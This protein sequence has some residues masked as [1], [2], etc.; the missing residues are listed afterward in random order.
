MNRFLNCLSLGLVTLCFL[1]LYT[2]CDDE[3]PTGGTDGGLAEGVTF[4]NNDNTIRIRLVAEPDRLSPF[5]TTSGYARP[6]YEQIFL[7]LLEHN[8]GTLNFEPALATARP[9]IEE[10]TEGPNA[11]GVKYTYEL[12]EGATFHDG[13]PVTVEDVIFSFKIPFNLNIT[14]AAP[15]RPSYGAVTDIV[16]DPDN[17]RRF[18]VITNQKYILAEDTYN[19]TGV[20]PK[21]VF[22]PDGL[23]DAYSYAQLKNNGEALASEAALQQFA[24]QFRSAEFSRSPDKL[25]GSGPYRLTGWEEGRH[26]TMSRVA[27]W[28]ADEIDHPVLEAHPDSLVFKIIT[29]QATA[30]T[31]VKSEEVDLARTLD[32]LALVDLRANE[33]MQQHYDMETP[34]TFNTYFVAL[35]NREPRLTDKRVRRA[36]AHVVDVQEIIDQA[37]AGSAT[38][39]VGPISPKKPGYNQSLQ[40]IERDYEKANELLSEAGWEDT[41]DNGIRDKV[42]DGELLELE[43]EYLYVPGGQFGETMAKLM[44]DGAARVGVGITLVARDMRTLLGQDA[45]SRNY[46]MYGGGAG[47]YH[48]PD[49]LMALWHTSGNTPRGQN[50]WQF[51][52]AETDALIEEINQTLDEEKRNELYRQFQEIVYEEQ[53]IIFLF[54][55]QE[56]MVISKRF[57]NAKAYE[58]LPNYNV[59]EWKLRESN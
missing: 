22:D 49:D 46:Q 53:P 7:P 58:V 19:T 18:T 20:Y 29:D 44:K 14:E 23:M 27:N 55:P 48:Q 56:R 9:E 13:Q 31:A 54:A 47:G 41:N 21:H 10:I 39:L 34:S 16:A 3:Q 51:G 33:F 1:F 2:S 5:L 42:V 57:T 38:R 11:G 50:R 12:F 30:V 52:N 36:L 35:N 4:K 40:L 45:A 43:L 15:F 24:D 26:I 37:F 25:I 59:R 8:K 17:P 6:I 28:W 32:A